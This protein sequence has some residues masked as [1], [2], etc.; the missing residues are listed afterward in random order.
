MTNRPY[1]LLSCAMSVDGYIDDTSPERL[2]L[3]NAEDLDR[4]DELRAG[5]DAIL[6]GAGTVRRDNPRLVVTSAERRTWREACGLPP[7]PLKVTMT[8]SGDLDPGL[9]FWVTGGAKLVYCPAAAAAKA[10]ER[11]GDLAEVRDLGEALTVPAVLDDLGE[12]GVHRLMVE[13]GSTIHTQFL[14]ADMVDEIQLAVAPF[15]VGNPAPRFV[16][17]G[18]F[19]DGP[20]RRMRLAEASMV[21]DMALLRYLSARDG[22]RP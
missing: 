17:D 9:R 1:V 2:I 6:V 14:L 15:F 12:R 21:G 11:L 5:S 18:A 13:G 4:V 7:Y 8:T 3:S 16:N 22:S 10:R 19:P 20:L